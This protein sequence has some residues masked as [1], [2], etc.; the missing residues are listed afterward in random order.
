LKTCANIFLIILLAQFTSQTVQGSVQ[1][2]TDRSAFDTATGVLDIENDCNTGSL[3]QVNSTI[4][5]S[6]FVISGTSGVFATFPNGNG[7]NTCDGTGY[8]RILMTEG[9]SVTFTFETPLMAFGF[10]TNPRS[11]GVSD[12]F[13]FTSSAGDGVFSMPTTDVTGFRGFITDAAISSFTLTDSDGDEWYGIDNLVGETAS[14]QSLPVELS[15]WSGRSRYGQ[16]ELTWRTDSETENMGFIIE[17]LG[18][19]DEGFKEIASLTEENALVGHGSTQQANSYR[20][21]DKNVQIGERFQYRLSDVAYNGKVTIHD[22]VNILVKD[23]HTQVK[24]TMFVLHQA[25]PNPFNP[26]TTIRYGL[27]EGSNV[28]LVIYDVRGQVVQTLESGHHSAG[29]YDVVWNGQTADGKTISTGIYFAR[30]VAGEY[31]QVIKMLYLK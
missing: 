1:V 21:V 12:V 13:S 25:Y 7:T 27:P 4:T 20:W 9:Y 10:D 31:S 24:P 2:Y 29:W 5:L 6:D 16:V 3:N 22:I 30:L 28:S 17:R 26:S 8:I 18:R 15:S 11:Q 19:E 14:D 23:D